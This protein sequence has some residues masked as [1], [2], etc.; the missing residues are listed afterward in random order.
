MSNATG[1]TTTRIYPSV[2]HYVITLVFS[3]RSLPRSLGS[4]PTRLV[5]ADKLTNRGAHHHCIS[6]SKRTPLIISSFESALR[7]RDTDTDTPSSLFLLSSLLF[8]LPPFQKAIHSF[9]SS[10]PLSLSLSYPS[11]LFLLFFSSSSCLQ[12]KEKKE[13]KKSNSCRIRIIFL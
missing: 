10:P 7:Y 2:R 5:F 4:P 1:L 12:K 8:P 6:R 9:I 13:E 3:S 11:C